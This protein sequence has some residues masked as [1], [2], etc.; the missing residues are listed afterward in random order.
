MVVNDSNNI[1]SWKY[2]STI[3][4]NNIYNISTEKSNVPHIRQY[5]MLLLVA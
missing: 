2:I 1:S 3:A 5:K 4:Q